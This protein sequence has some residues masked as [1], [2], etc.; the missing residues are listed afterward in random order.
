M[1]QLQ[2]QQREEAERPKNRE[3]DYP[4]ELWRIFKV[5]NEI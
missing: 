2:Q 1:A 4:K 5:E 3:E